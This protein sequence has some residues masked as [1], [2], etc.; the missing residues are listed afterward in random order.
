MYLPETTPDSTT[1]LPLL[2]AV[3]ASPGNSLRSWAES[4]L[5]SLRTATS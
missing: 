5:K 4:S 3:I 1:S 2:V